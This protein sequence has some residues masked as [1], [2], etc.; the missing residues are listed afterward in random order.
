MRQGQRHHGAARV[1]AVQDCAAAFGQC[2]DQA[3]AT[4]LGRRGPGIA[5]LGCGEALATVA[6][7]E[8]QLAAGQALE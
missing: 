7:L 1:A 4:E 2:A 5:E 6:Y 8:L 3:L